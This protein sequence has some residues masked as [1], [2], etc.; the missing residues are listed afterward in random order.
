M[1]VPKTGAL[2]L[3]D[4]PTNIFNFLTTLRRRPVFAL[5]ELRLARPIFKRGLIFILP[6]LLAEY[7]ARVVRRH[8]FEQ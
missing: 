7:R 3:G 5:A 6:C 8:L 1:P 4:A 2:P